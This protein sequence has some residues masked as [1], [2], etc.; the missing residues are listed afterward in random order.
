MWQINVKN[1]TVDF[2]WPNDKIRK[3]HKSYE[4]LRAANSELVCTI[5]TS[6]WNQLLWSVIGYWW[7]VWVCL[8]SCR[9]SHVPV[10][11]D[12]VQHLELAQ[13]LARVFNHHYGEFF[14][15]PRALLSKLCI[16]AFTWGTRRHTLHAG[17]SIQALQAHRIHT[18][19]HTH[20]HTTHP[21]KIQGLHVKVYIRAVFLSW[22]V[23]TPKVWVFLQSF[24]DFWR[25]YSNRG[26]YFEIE[27]AGSLPFSCLN[28]KREKGALG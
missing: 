11:E 21:V 24:N 16:R 5:S 6:R 8:W 4:S 27:K 2:S 20:T 23:A 7:W 12:Q 26:F 19:T 28:H 1:F 9:S 14:P 13:D 17:H 25:K 3:Q 18:H 15:E 10:G 22:W